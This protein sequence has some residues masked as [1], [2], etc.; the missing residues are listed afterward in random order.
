[1]SRSVWKRR[2]IGT[3]YCG[4]CRRAAAGS[5][6][7]DEER[8]GLRIAAQRRRD[9]DLQVDRPPDCSVSSVLEHLELPQY[10][11]GGPSAIAQG[12]RRSSA[13]GRDAAWQAARSSVNPMSATR[14]ARITPQR[15]CGIRP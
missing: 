15:E 10:A 1:M 5:A 8:I 7:E 3:R 12:C 6:F 14:M 4:E 13:A 11:S 2:N 9:D